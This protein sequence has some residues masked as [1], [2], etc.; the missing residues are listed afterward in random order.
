MPH[1][2]QHNTTT[3]CHST[4]YQPPCPAFSF[5]P[6]LKLPLFPHACVTY[7][8][9]ACGE[10]NNSVDLPWRSCIDSVSYWGVDQ[11]LPLLVFHSFAVSLIFQFVVVWEHGGACAF[12]PWS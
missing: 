12:L 2:K 11:S 6:S 9:N 4:L 10:R 8:R 5:L 7:K 3:T 1:A